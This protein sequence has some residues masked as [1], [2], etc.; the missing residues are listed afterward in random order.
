MMKEACLS[1][2]EGENTVENFPQVGRPE[3][4]KGL[5]TQPEI[6]VNGVDYREPLPLLNYEWT[7]WYLSFRKIII[8]SFSLKKIK[9]EK[10]AS[11]CILEA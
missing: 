6:L 2:A 7:C 1:S 5:T 3:M 11:L 10:H 9:V 8:T 4:K